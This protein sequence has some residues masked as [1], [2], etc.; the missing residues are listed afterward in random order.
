MIPFAVTDRYNDLRF[1]LVYAAKSSSRP[2]L[3]V[4]Y[5]ELLTI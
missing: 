5:G 4:A 3:V 2:G 1:S